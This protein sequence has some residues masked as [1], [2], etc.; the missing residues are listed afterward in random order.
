MLDNQQIIEKK[1]YKPT[2][3]PNMRKG[4]PSINPKGRPAAGQ[5][6]KDRMAMWYETKTVGEI[7]ELI[8]NPKK[9]NKLAAIDASICQ[10]VSE[11]CKKTGQSAVMIIF[12]RLLGKP[13]ITADLV[14]THQLGSRLDEAEKLIIIEGDA[15]ELPSLPSTNK[16]LP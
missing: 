1:P 7:E 3:N 4:G 8:L 9:W 6:L 10:L 15:E 12:D 5:S 13:A 16:Q 2:G 11:S 14:V